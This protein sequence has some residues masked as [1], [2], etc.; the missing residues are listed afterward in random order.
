MSNLLVMKTGPSHC[1]GALAEPG[2][3]SLKTRRHA[4]AGRGRRA[5]LRTL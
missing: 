2:T 3:D 5:G 4:L 1:I